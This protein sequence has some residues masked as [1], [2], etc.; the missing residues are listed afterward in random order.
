METE[1]SHV[2]EGKIT[3]ERKKHKK[4]KK[5][6]ARVKNNGREEKEAEGKKGK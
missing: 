3:M 5:L 4:R 2:E 6:H 1:K